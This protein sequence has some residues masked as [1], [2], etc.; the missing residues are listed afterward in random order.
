LG[1]K[2]LLKEDM[3]LLLL[4]FVLLCFWVLGFLLLTFG[5]GRLLEGKWIA[6]GRIAEGK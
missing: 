1:I 2:D 3:R 4:D 5:C 6:E